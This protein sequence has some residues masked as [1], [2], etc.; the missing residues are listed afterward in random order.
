M[1]AGFIASLTF[2]MISLAENDR[3]LGLWSF[4]LAGMILGV[5]VLMVSNVRYPS[6][7]KIDLKTKAN[8]WS[9]LGFALLLGLIVKWTIYTPA[10]IFV[11][12]LVLPL[13]LG[14]KKKAKG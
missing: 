10:A 4:V 8:V 9:L 6:F 5:S 3:S 7:K 1:A 14:R 11:V 2:V 12:Y 13:F